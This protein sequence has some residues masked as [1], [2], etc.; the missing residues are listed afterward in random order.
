MPPWRLKAAVQGA[1]SLLPEP[2]RWNRFLQSYV[3]GS[4][5]LGDAYFIEKW[6]QAAH[7]AEHAARR[8]GIA[9]ARVMELGTG[10]FPIVP[11]GLA[12]AGAARVDTVDLHDL[13]RH[14]KG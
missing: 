11:V 9:G 4:L 13:L 8:G 3:T 6:Q 10:W 1:L 14:D 7:H 12:L 5:E 2:Q